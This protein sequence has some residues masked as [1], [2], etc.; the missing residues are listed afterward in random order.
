M[1]LGPD[2][3]RRPH[4][5]R[6]YRN[7][8]TSRPLFRSIT[9]APTSPAAKTHGSVSHALRLV[10]ETGTTGRHGHW[11]VKKE[12]ELRHIQAV[13]RHCDVFAGPV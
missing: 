5:L 8:L 9:I 6:L 10:S 13:Q 2:P 11:N 4:P 3:R 1:T 7:V 12:E